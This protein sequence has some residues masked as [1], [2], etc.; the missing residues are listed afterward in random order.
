MRAM[1]LLFRTSV[2]RIYKT[3]AETGEKVQAMSRRQEEIVSR[4]RT[5]NEERM[6]RLRYVQRLLLSLCS[7][8]ES[9]GC[10]WIAPR[11][12]YSQRDEN[13]DNFLGRIA[14]IREP[15]TLTM[16]LKTAELVLNSL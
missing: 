8:L 4:L 16:L 7:F 2:S 5:E 11:L 9:N 10:L 1:T 6:R 15:S 3:L 12:L 13:K 14:Q